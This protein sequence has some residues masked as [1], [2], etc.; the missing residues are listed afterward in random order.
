M[1][2]TTSATNRKELKA[3]AALLEQKK[4]ATIS[5]LEQK[6]KNAAGQTSQQTGATTPEGQEEPHP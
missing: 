3:E 2:N 5:M 1:V 6:K 4:R